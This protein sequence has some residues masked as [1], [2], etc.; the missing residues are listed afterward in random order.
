MRLVEVS[1][2]RR[3]RRRSAQ[4]QERP[5]CWVAPEAPRLWRRPG[6]PVPRRPPEQTR[7]SWLLRAL[8]QTPAR[9]DTVARDWR[10]WRGRGR[11]AADRRKL[12]RRRRS[13]VRFQRPFPMAFVRSVAR[14]RWRQARKRRPECPTPGH[15]RAR[16][17][18]T[19]VS[20]APGGQ[21][22]PTRRRRRSRWRVL[23]RE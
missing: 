23:L 6:W 10:P 20:R 9:S 13:E 14:K 17:R 5:A 1:L 11:P 12:R 21:H 18:N 2:R 3:C 15:R 22:V 4:V 8:R 16:A 7:H 19:V